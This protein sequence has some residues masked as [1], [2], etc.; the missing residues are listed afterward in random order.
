MNN[1]IDETVI[2]SINTELV[3]MG[4][5]LKRNISEIVTPAADEIPLIITLICH[6]RHLKASA[7]LIADLLCIFLNIYRETLGATTQIG[8]G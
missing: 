7:E 3:E 6:V 8:V 1:D 2:Q 4:A 5:K